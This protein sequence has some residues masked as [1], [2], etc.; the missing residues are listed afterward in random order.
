MFHIYYLVQCSQTLGDV[1]PILQMKTPRFRESKE[2]ASE[3]RIRV[4][5]QEVWMQRLCSSFIVFWVCLIGPTSKA[6]F[7]FIFSSLMVP[8]SSHHPCL[9]QD[10]S[11]SLLVSLLLFYNPLISSSYKEIRQSFENIYRIL[12]DSL[13]RVLHAPHKDLQGSPWSAACLPLWF[14][15]HVMFPLIHKPAVPLAC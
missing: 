10:C 9:V 4:W 11:K 6:C 1:T 5:I 3:W 12:C 7:E 15:L 2:L 13:P 14:Y 8:P